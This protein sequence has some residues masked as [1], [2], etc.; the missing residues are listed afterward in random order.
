MPTLFVTGDDDRI[1][2]PED[3]LQAAI[4]VDDAEVVTIERSGHIPHEERP[5]EFVGAVE[6]FLAPADGAP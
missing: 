5:E 3:T 1:V 6:E 2:P 4:L